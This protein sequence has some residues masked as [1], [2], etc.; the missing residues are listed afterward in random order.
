MGKR[1][2]N[3][4]IIAGEASGDLYGAELAKELMAARPEVKVS[5]MGGAAMKAAGVEIIVD[6]TEL[7]IVGIAEVIKKIPFFVGLLKRLSMQ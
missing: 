5:G 4:W 3:I 6:S 7:G 1:A 2:E